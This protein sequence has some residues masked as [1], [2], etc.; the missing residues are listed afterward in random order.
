[1]FGFTTTTN[2]R[3]IF[4]FGLVLFLF[5]LVAIL[6]LRSFRQVDDGTREI[7]EIQR[8]VDASYKLALYVHRLS[9]HQSDLIWTRDYSRVERFADALEN[10]NQQKDRLR[11]EAPG[12]PEGA[13]IERLDAI[14]E[15]L[16]NLFFA[17]LVPAVQADDRQ[18]VED[19]RHRSAE[20]ARVV[21]DLSRRLRLSFER[22]IYDAT[23]EAIAIGRRALVQTAL[24]FVVAVLL[25]VSVS[26]Y[27]GG[28]IVRPIQRLIEGTEVVSRGDF[29]REVPTPKSED[30]RR[31]A[32]SFN[33]MVRELRD[34]EQQ[35]IQAE[36]MAS[37]GRL[38]A[39]V[40]HEINNPVGV[41]LGYIKVML[42]S[43]EPDHPQY[44][45]FKTIEEEALQCKRIVE[46]LLHL[47]RPAR[48]KRARF[49]VREVV[50]EVLDTASRN[51]PMD[52][53]K[54]S[55]EM[56][57]D[58]V[59]GSG[60]R[61]KIRQV[62][63]NVVMNALEAMPNGGQLR[64][65]AFTTDHGP[66]RAAANGAIVVE[67]ADTGIGVSE[68]DLPHLFEPFFSTKPSGTGLGLS[69]SYGIVKAHGGV[70][71]VESKRNKGTKFRIQLPAA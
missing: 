62:V 27:L 20:M 49:D 70:I 15:D 3:L 5:A 6:T 34:R 45:D 50:Q 61:A 24:I 13:W 68:A 47:A 59:L 51:R 10:L 17:E 57:N 63:S 53:V 31:L 14:T 12:I 65:R 23:E 64:V 2:F 39:G 42:R 4:A 36:K 29:S 28:S 8:G 52:D 11:I 55:V 46:D 58:P 67:I 21:D 41:I 54:V 71:K 38:A 18:R 48:V 60:E 35:L 19:V 44:D 9:I 7:R 56:P 16:G 66:A 69:I 37:L 25:S 43:L 32:S 30:F 22:K 33:R 26:V 40:A 1:M